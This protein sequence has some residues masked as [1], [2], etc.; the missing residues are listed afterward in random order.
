MQL[1]SVHVKGRSRPEN[2]GRQHSQ[3]GQGPLGLLLLQDE[4]GWIKHRLVRAGRQNESTSWSFL[5]Y[6]LS[7]SFSKCALKG[8]GVPSP[9][10]RSGYYISKR[11]GIGTSCICMKIALYWGEVS[12]IKL[13]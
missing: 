9:I 5:N 3:D 12:T 2:E 1:C 8:S 7:S 13:N 10:K 11:V 4:G 6:L